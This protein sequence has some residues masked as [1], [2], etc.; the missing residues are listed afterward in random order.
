MGYAIF[1]AIDILSAGGTLNSGPFTVILRAM[2]NGLAL[3]EQLSQH[4]E[5]AREQRGAIRNRIRELAG[6]LIGRESL[7]LKAW[8]FDESMEKA[9]PILQDVF[10]PEKSERV[11]NGTRVVNAL[12]LDVRTV[13]DVLVLNDSHSSPLEEESPTFDE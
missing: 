1:S 2:N 9:L 7:A 8:V 13:Q 6:S 10:Y 3:V 12:R 5:S 11:I 4:W